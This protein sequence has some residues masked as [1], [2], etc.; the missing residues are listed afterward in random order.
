MRLAAFVYYVLL[1]S[2]II[3]SMIALS[4]YLEFTPWSIG[5]AALFVWII[6]VYL[7][8]CKF[9][10]LVEPSGEQNEHG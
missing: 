5:I 6:S 8:A 9:L 10:P 1:S 7:C 4:Y 3:S 2:L